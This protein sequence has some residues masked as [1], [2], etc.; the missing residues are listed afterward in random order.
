MYYLLPRKTQWI[1][2]LCGSIVFYYLAG[3]LKAGVFLTLTVLST[4]YAGM[5][6]DLITEAETAKLKGGETPL[7]RDEKKAVK[8]EAAKARH[9]WLVAGMVFNFGIL[10]VLKYL[11][12]LIGNINGVLGRLGAEAALPVF[13]WILPLGISFYTFQSTGY[14]LDLSNGR[15]RAERNLFRYALF[16]SY[17]PQIIQGPISK[18]QDLAPRLFAEHPFNEQKLREGFLR[19]LWGY[20]KKLVI[21]ERAALVI[22]EVMAN[23]EAEGYAGFTVFLGVLAFGIQM[24]GDFSGGIDMIC[25]VSEMLDIDLIENFRQPYF[26]KDISEFWQRWHISLG[27]WMK[28]YVFYPIALSKPFNRMQKSIKKKW[29]LYYGKMLPAV[30][31]SFI[32]FLLVGLW[33]G[34]AWHYIA[35]GVYHAIFTSIDSLI[36]K[37]AAR[38]LEVLHIDGSS[39]GWNVFRMLRTIF[40]VTI[41]RYFD[42]ALSLRIALGML[43]ATFSSFN[44]WIFFDGSLYKHG[45]N[46]KELS[47]LLLAVAVLLVVDIVN[48]RGTR[49]RAVV[50]KQG[51]VFRQI[52]YFAAIFVILIFGLYGPGYDA[53]SF[54]Y[55]GF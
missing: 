47:I 3:G 49:V 28:D 25:G 30:I 10:G 14:L 16:A 50:A 45:L 41:G 23:Y 8:A 32:V 43:K 20:F 29:G 44:P 9:R 11:N 2:L 53:A 46:G 42:C 13:Q 7:S 4:W 36:E 35:F 19:L 51:F 17:F 22:N 38:A 15:T 54:I 12:F 39:V 24:Y 34:P 27:H 40:F 31:A 37:P 52:V 55:Q 26:A 48:E 6:M 5:R 18:H 33:H 1:V 21:A